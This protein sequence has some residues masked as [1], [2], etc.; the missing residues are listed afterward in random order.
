MKQKWLI[1]LAVAALCC[2]GT[3][4]RG[5]SATGPDALVNPDLEDPGNDSFDVMEDKL[6]LFDELDTPSN[7][8]DISE[9]EVEFLKGHRK[10][11]TDKA[12]DPPV[13]VRSPLATV[14]EEGDEDGHQRLDAYSPV[15]SPQLTEI[16]E[17]HDYLVQH[18]LVL[19]LHNQHM[20]T[21]FRNLQ[22]LEDEFA[23]LAGEL[24][25][26][27][28][29]LAIDA[30]TRQLLINFAA[31][32][33]Y[34][35]DELTYERDRPPPS[36]YDYYLQRTIDFEAI[37]EENEEK[38]DEHQSTKEKIEQLSFPSSAAT[39]ANQTVHIEITSDE[40]WLAARKAMGVPDSPSPVPLPQK[41][42]AKPVGWR[43]G[44]DFLQEAQPFVEKI[45]AHGN[46][47][48]F[49]R[50]SHRHLFQVHHHSHIHRHHH[51]LSRRKLV[52]NRHAMVVDTDS[53]FRYPEQYERNPWAKTRFEG[54]VR[55]VLRDTFDQHSLNETNSTL[56]DILLYYN[57]T[58]ALLE[59][60]E[61]DLYNSTRNSLVDP[62]DE[63]HH[64]QRLLS[65]S[66]AAYFVLEQIWNDLN[67]LNTDFHTIPNTHLNSLAFFDLREQYDKVRCQYVNETERQGFFEDEIQKAHGE[68]RVQVGLTIAA[69]EAC[70]DDVF[71][72][73]S[74]IEFY[75]NY[76]G[77]DIPGTPA[78][79]EL[80]NRTK[81]D[82]EELYELKGTAEARLQEL[83]NELDHF[84]DP[85]K[86][87]V[88][89]IEK[90]AKSGGAAVLLGGLLALISLLVLS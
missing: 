17:T 4:A 30:N 31:H 41:K 46:H 33:T 39:N 83:R 14:E 45:A 24:S 1:F 70:Q 68:F 58:Y 3:A 76:K 40:T 20:E 54:Y 66:Q 86:D 62:D 36:L 90:Y 27:K 78:F 22:S 23:T 82:I 13:I 79:M 51:R 52:K 2:R 80:I 8:L 29:K 28:S 61:D 77:K 84:E 25:S 47:R 49:S 10:D 81:D 72:I 15:I 42:P 21:A 19:D 55:P 50:H 74:L 26:G 32:L 43:I 59:T 56:D 16:E 9:S 57:S 87:F 44:S 12:H 75:R 37:V 5:S 35:E 64:Y 67:Q 60:P 6:E 63:V 18:D 38:E 89:V 85:K 73:L 34:I 65:F 69:I 71:A 53:G 7:D 48:G 11:S 88:Y